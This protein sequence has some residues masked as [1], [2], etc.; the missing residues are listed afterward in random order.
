MLK[1]YF[2]LILLS[3]L[4]ISSGCSIWTKDTNVTVNENGIHISTD[5]N[6][7]NIG[8]TGKNVTTDN[9]EVE[10]SGMNI[11]ANTV[12]TTTEMLNNNLNSSEEELTSNDANLIEG[13]E[14]NIVCEDVYQTALATYKLNYSDCYVVP[15]YGSCGSDVSK[16]NNLLLLMD[17]SGSMALKISTERKIDI[18]KRVANSFLQTLGST[19]NVG[20]LLYGHK[21]SNRTA[22]R[23]VS[24]KGIEEVYSL[25]PLNTQ[26]ISTA[27]NL[28][29]PVGWTPIA[30]T[31]TK[32]RSILS[33]YPSDQYNNAIILVSDGEETCGGDPL[34]AVTDLTTTDI[35]AIT[36]VIGFDV[37]G[38]AEAQ[39]RNIAEKGGGTYYT[40]RNSAEL[41][42]ALKNSAYMKCAAQQQRDW[43][44][45][46]RF[47]AECKRRMGE[48][49]RDMGE[50]IRNAN[51][52][53]MKYIKDRWGERLSSITQQLD[54]MDKTIRAARPSEI[55]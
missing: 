46:M 51:V 32:A 28:L 48:E 39:L 31:L 19:V 36:S 52:P 23:P 13:K 27:I 55:P 11:N 20:L 33:Q 40:A 50:T 18:A 6:N 24:C 1:R 5:N 37:D 54:D 35:Q 30:D 26:K 41:E 42:A 25:A 12:D 16:Q 4:F 21:G 15:D 38:N 2:L 17:S 45:D 49:T 8:T 14:I 53:C 9:V 34:Q 22:D 29:S 3:S 43:A 44:T 7:I 47:M 10:T